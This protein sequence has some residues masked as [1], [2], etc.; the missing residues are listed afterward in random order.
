MK[1][2]ILFGAA[3]LSV[4]AMKGHNFYGE[5]ED[6]A[7]AL[8]QIK[9]AAEKAAK[10]AL[11]DLLKAGMSSE[12]V[13]KALKTAVDKAVQELTIKDVDG[14]DKS[15]EAIVK[16]MQDQAEKQAAAIKAIQ[17]KALDGQVNDIM[18]QIKAQFDAN[19][20]Q[21]GAVAKNGNGSVKFVVKAVSNPISVS[22][23]GDRVIFG[24]REQGVDRVP[25]PQR[26]VFDIISVMNGGPGSNPL[27]WVE[28]VAGTGAP[29]WTAENAEKPGM[30]WTYVE[31]TVVAQMI[32]V[33][34][35]VTKQAL[36]NWPILE[37]E[38][39]SELSRKLYNKLDQA[40]I[41]GDGTG[42]S[43]YGIEYYATAF[44][45]SSL[46][47]TIEDAN[48]MDVI[49]AAIGQV[50]K[51]GAT[52]SSELGGFNPNY[53]LVSE[54][55]ATRMDLAKN[56]NGTYLLPPFTSADNT[57]IK[58]VTV[59]TSNFIGDDEFIVGD[60]SR[61]LF[62]IVDGL[63]IDVGYINAQFIFNQLT[64]RAELYGMGRV[65]NNEKP[66]FVKGTFE[67]AISQLNATS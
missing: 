37:Q 22:S 24:L 52:A 28:M 57:R 54:D 63:S 5:D 48:V 39:R 29:A 65:K 4:M 26:F 45:A 35:V 61:Y 16:A 36:L 12:D 53:V 25:L 47:G 66:A 17:D 18:A 62:N 27:S 30:N 51:G 59:I 55:A 43:I 40:I 33:Y 38:I 32:A 50:R 60:F 8:K 46:A 14:A 44:D 2:N 21:L 11:P 42:N 56:D 49:R 9:A 6:K 58:G 23:F 15:I 41:G 1:S 13:T 64:I 31:Q 67:D 34:T 7:E 10:D 20:A 19:E 3:I